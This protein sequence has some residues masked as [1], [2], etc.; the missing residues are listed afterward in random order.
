MKKNT[1]KLS[2][3]QLR[4]MISESVKKVIKEYND[5]DSYLSYL[6]AQHEKEM[7]YGDEDMVDDASDYFE[8]KLALCNI[9]Y[10]EKIKKIEMVLNWFNRKGNSW[11][12]SYMERALTRYIKEYKEFMSKIKSANREQVYN[13]YGEDE[14]NEFFNNLTGND[15]IDAFLCFD[16]QNCDEAVEA[17]ENLFDYN[18]LKCFV[19]E[20]FGVKVFDDGEGP[21]Y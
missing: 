11:Y 5:Y 19:E 15:A 12:R 6:E 16:L 20:T 2:E 21:D 7:G 13:Y 1:I 4:S 10:P 14:V 9:P 8:Q 18:S 17:L 3:A